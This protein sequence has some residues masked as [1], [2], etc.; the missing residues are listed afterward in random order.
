MNKIK[1]FII[2]I[3]ITIFFTFSFILCFSFKQNNNLPDNNSIIKITSK[4]QEFIAFDQILNMVSSEIK[5]DKNK[6]TWKNIMIEYVNIDEDDE[7]EMLIS[8][9]EEIHKGH[10]F[11]YDYKDKKYQKIFYR[12]WAV[13]KIHSH[14]LVVAS[15][16]KLIHQLKA[17]IIHAEKGQVW[18]LWS[19]ILDGYNYTNPFKGIEIHGHYYVDTNGILHYYYKVENTNENAK[20][21]KREVYEEIYIWDYIHNKFKLKNKIRII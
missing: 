17:Y 10:F 7:L 20:V 19:G 11:I 6:I 2:I 18:T 4:T 1:L 5:Q 12:P 14:E 3:L 9:R 15:G 8:Y 21:L 16:S 13:E